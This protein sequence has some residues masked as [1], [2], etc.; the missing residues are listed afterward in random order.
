MRMV[1][2]VAL[3]AFLGCDSGK[4][5]APAP[6][7]PPPAPV[8]IPSP[9]K[10][11]PAPPAA[12]TASLSGTVAIQ[13]KALRQGTAALTAECAA[14]HA[15]RYTLDDVVVDGENRVQWAFVYVKKGLEGKTFAPPAEA[16]LVDQVGCR[17]VPHV[18][19]I[20]VGQK[21]IFQNSDNFLHNVHGLPFANPEFNFGQ[22]SKG[23]RNELVFTAS[24]VMAFVK[25]DVHSFMSTYAG[26]LDHP[27]YAVTDASGKYELKGLPAGKYTIEVW[28]EKYKSVEKEVTVEGQATQDFSLVDPK[29]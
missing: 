7:V 17:Y 24:E 6:G 1:A 11:P 29:Q 2:L 28:H 16:V 12:G 22:P 21:L 18:F 26:V 9:P 20:R 27:F 3:A 5:P 13:G 10:P 23:L 8:V 14:L 19:G 15:N 25:C 4:P